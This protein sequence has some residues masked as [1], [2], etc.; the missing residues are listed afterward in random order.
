MTTTVPAAEKAKRKLFEGMNEDVEP[1]EFDNLPSDRTDEVWRDIKK[2]SPL[3]ER[4]LSAL[5]NDSFSQWG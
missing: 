4:K 2:P 3:S 1:F 5:R